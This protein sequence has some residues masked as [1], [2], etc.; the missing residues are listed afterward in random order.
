[1]IDDNVMV[2]R[3]LDGQARTVRLTGWGLPH[4][5][6]ALKTKHRATVT[7]NAGSGEGE[8]TVMGASLEPTPAHGAWHTRW[9]GDTTGGSSITV[10]DAPVLTATDAVLLFESICDEGQ[11]VEITWNHVVRRGILE[12]FE[13]SYLTVHDVEWSCTFNWHG[14]GSREAAPPADL[15]GSAGKLERAADALDAGVANVKA[16]LAPSLPIDVRVMA[17]LQS[18]VRT[19]AATA[20]QVR[21]LTSAVYGRASPS[22][23]AR[24]RAVSLL[25]TMA[26]DAGAASARL[27]AAT[28]VVPAVDRTRSTFVAARAYQS[29]VAQALRAVRYEAAHRR[30]V[31][32]AAAAEE[33]YAVHIGGEGE[34]LR[35][36]ARRYYGTPYPWRGL[37]LWNG[38]TTDRLRAGQRIAVPPAHR[39]PTGDEQGA[40]P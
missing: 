38:L 28:L 13:A 7:W 30:A 23:D 4:R 10:N 21:A 12:D 9:L 31:L 11:E 14:K 37:M 32:A 36:V 26:A 27:D 24:A 33:T 17:T 3:E 15:Q 16:T 39:L 2:L 25:N 1:M 40:A 35:S 22:A 6:F 18:G 29:G 19:M 34:D 8:T 20:A 5:P